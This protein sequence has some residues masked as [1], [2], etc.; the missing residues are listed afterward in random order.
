M[1]PPIQLSAEEQ[2]FLD[3]AEPGT[4]M[5]DDPAEKAG[6]TGCDPGPDAEF[7]E[8]LT[9]A[10]RVTPQPTRKSQYDFRLPGR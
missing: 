9:D 4:A 7:E 3:G 10:D 1:I 2:A 5:D 8:L 6:A